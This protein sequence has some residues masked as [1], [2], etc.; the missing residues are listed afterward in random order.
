MRLE[1]VVVAPMDVFAV[2]MVMFA[3]GV[4]ICTMRV[5]LAP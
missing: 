5:C 3:T 2:I 1:H 4:D